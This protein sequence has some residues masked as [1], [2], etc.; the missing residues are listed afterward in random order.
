MADQ[1]AFLRLHWQARVV[2]VWAW[3]PAACAPLLSGEELSGE[4]LGWTSRLWGQVPGRRTWW[5]RGRD[6]SRPR[7]PSF[8]AGPGSPA[9]RSSR[10]SHLGLGGSSNGGV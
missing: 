7:T 4:D 9:T 5:E 8:L 3:R 1:Q 6:R 10:P 2:Q